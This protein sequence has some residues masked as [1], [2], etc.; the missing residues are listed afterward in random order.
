MGEYYKLLWPITV[1]QPTSNLM[2]LS[3]E[4]FDEVT[5]I[6]DGAEFAIDFEASG[7]D[8]HAPVYWVRCVSFHNDNYSCSI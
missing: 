2:R 8:I 4:V 7:L 1:G 3:S 5:A 6:L